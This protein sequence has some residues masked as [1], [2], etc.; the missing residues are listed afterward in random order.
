MPDHILTFLILPLFG[1]NWRLGHWVQG[2][3]GL[4]KLDLVLENLLSYVGLTASDFDISNLNENV[5]GF[6][7]EDRSSLRDILS[8]LA[9]PYF[10]DVTESDGKIKFIKRGGETVAELTE[11][12]LMPLADSDNRQRLMKS[13][14]ADLEL[15][16]QIEISYMSRTAN[17]T[18]G[19][20]I[21][22]RQTVNS[23]EKISIDLPLVFSDQ[24]AKQISDKSLYTAWINRTFYKF[25]LS[26]KYSFI[27]PGDIVT[28]TLDGVENKIRVTS[29]SLATFL[30]IEGLAE[31]ISTYDFYTD[32]ADTKIIEEVPKPIS[33]TIMELLDLPAF[34]SDSTNTNY[35]RIAVAA[36][37]DN[38]KG[39]NIYRSDDGGENG[40]NSFNLMSSITAQ[41]TMGYSLNSLEENMDPN[42]FDNASSLQ[43]SL[44]TGELSSVTELG[45]LNGANAAIIGSE[46]IQFQNATLQGDGTYILTKF[47]R[48]RLGTEDQI[49][50]HEDGDRFIII[51][52]SLFEQQIP[53]SYIGLLKYYKPVTVGKT[54]AGTDEQSFKFLGR[55]FKPYSVTQIEGERDVSD[56]L[57]ISWKRRTRV[58]GEW[59]DFVDVPLSEETEKYEIDILD[60][61]TVVRTITATATSAEYSAADQTTDFGSPQ[62]S[63][64]VKIYQ[65]S[66]MVGRG[67]EA[68]AII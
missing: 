24:I 11:D 9:T 25:S 32:P 3:L 33:N 67:I 59:R 21:S 13:R 47:L 34:P 53:L 23:Q 43:V 30:E 18:K 49:N 50:E 41:A 65:M 48:G 52:G 68:T 58:G 45:M 61:S 14:K 39:S 2:K 36:E 7:I 46:I 19:T 63:I 15:P 54:V 28:L 31:D 37:K 64:T 10:F 6:I 22:Q 29:V 60:G 40:G 12:D 16:K 56:N 20:Q 27:D 42:N 4:T 57:T 5:E 35:L 1:D 62:S 66:A 55:K 8:T 51:N 44:F 26:R 17:Y 38:W